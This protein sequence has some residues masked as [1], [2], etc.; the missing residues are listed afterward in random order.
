V[1]YECPNAFNCVYR[2]HIILLE[3]FL[4]MFIIFSRKNP[5]FGCFKNY[6]HEIQTYCFGSSCLNYFFRI[7]FSKFLEFL[8]YLWGFKMI[9]A[10][11]GIIFKLPIFMKI[12][13]IC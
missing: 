3:N 1:L 7:C 5:I 4:E 12:L 10:S 6:F 11:F 13:I 2:H 8:K 9:L